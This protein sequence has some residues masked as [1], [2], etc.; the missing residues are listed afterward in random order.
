M[1]ANNLML[2][3]RATND[4]A[5]V[6]ASVQD[7]LGL[8]VEAAQAAN[9]AMAQ[10]AETAAPAM[11]AASQAATAAQSAAVPAIDTQGMAAYGQTLNQ[12]EMPNVE[13]GGLAAFGDVFGTVKDQAVD[14]LTTLGGMRGGVHALQDIAGMAGDAMDVFGLRLTNLQNPMNLARGGFSGLV[15]LGG[16]LRTAMSGIGPAVATAAGP[17]STLASGG[18]TRLVA[19]GGALIPVIRGVGAA[20]MTVAMNPVG[21]IVTGLV[22]L[23]AAGIAIWKNW[24]TISAKATEIWGMISGFLGGVMDGITTKFSEVWNGITSFFSGIW[25]GLIGIVTENWQTILGIIFP[26]AGLAMLIAENWGAITETVGEIW[27][28]VVG[29][30]QEWW[31]NLIGVIFPEEGGLLVRFQELFSGVMTWFDENVLGFFT[32]LPDRIGELV[33]GIADVVAAPFR[34]AF[35]AVRGFINRIVDAVN[36][37]PS[38]EVPKLVP[39]IGGKTFSLPKLPRVPDFEF[40]EGGILRRP[41]VALAEREPEVIAP[42][43][44]LSRMLPAGAGGPPVIQVINRGN[45]VTERQLEDVIVKAYHRAARLGRI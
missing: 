29:K 44:A 19:M 35:G 32:S 23:V 39:G 45:I 2:V 1:T 13:T 11:A 15:G 24:D 26:A 37:F 16:T 4:A 20:L 30:V 17:L 10:I 38:I 3:I 18:L 14:F 9:D 7:Q 42:L 27:G 36:S 43:S 31:N 25:E 41:I 6:L 28:Q 8:I 12:M 33:S 21:L 34:A 22:G 5:K 40:A